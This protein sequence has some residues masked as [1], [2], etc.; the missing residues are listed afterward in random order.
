[1]NEV[2]CS[3]GTRVFTFQH[4]TQRL[5]VRLRKEHLK[6]RGTH[7]LC[8]TFQWSWLTWHSDSFPLPDCSSGWH[9]EKIILSKPLHLPFVLSAWMLSLKRRR[10]KGDI[11][12][13]GSHSGSPAALSCST[14]LQTTFPSFVSCDYR[15]KLV[16]FPTGR[17]PWPL[18]VGTGMSMFHILILFADIINM[19]SFSWYEVFKI[20]QSS[21]RQLLRMIF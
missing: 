8:S 7:S 16:L 1:M 9:E 5:S 20:I 2:S 3:S 14:S 10:L 18:A 13:A 12:K 15:R 17:V 19:S 21:S 11:V 4:W 6:R